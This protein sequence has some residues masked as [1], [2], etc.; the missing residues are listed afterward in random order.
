MSDTANRRYDPADAN[1]INREYLD[2]ILVEMRIMDAVKADTTL[3]IFGK[4]FSSPIMTPAFSHLHQVGAD[5]LTQMEEYS[6]AAA[7]LNVANLAGMESNDSF[8]KISAQCPGTIRI[9]KPYADKA[10]VYREM[11]QAIALGAIAVGMDIDH[12]FGKL[13]EYDVVDGFPMGPVTTELLTEYV[14]AAK[15]PFIAKGVLSV[16]D[17]LKCR[18]AGCAAIIVSHHHG[19]IPFGVPPLMVLPEIR[20]AIGDD[21]KILVDCGI[22]DGYDAFKALALGADAVC[23][24][25]AML[26]PLVKEGTEGVVKKL[27]EMNGQLMELM[28]YTNTKTLKDMDS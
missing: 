23:V 5:G 11:E 4:T 21:M 27:Q 10:L 25:R 20:D 6:K 9:I 8:E 3:E 7:Q 14:R 1:A 28:E 24:G 2:S 13:G 18:E 12:V 16:T 22:D 17:A 19:R 26:E 15:V